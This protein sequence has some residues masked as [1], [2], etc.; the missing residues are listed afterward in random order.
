M[1]K[2]FKHSKDSKLQKMDGE[3]GNDPNNDKTEKYRT[4]MEDDIKCMMEQLKDF[5][6]KKKKTCKL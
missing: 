2:A 1:N 3:E 5:A 6:T 4:L